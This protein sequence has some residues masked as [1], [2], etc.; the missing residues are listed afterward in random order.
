M[1]QQAILIVSQSGRFLA[2][3]A[4]NSGYPVWVADCFGDSDTLSVASR[5]LPINDISNPL[6]IL[7]TIITLSNEDP[8]T[9]IYGSGIESFH[10]LLGRLPKHIKL[11][12][13][14]QHTVEKLKNPSYF[15]NTLNKL[16]IPYPKITLTPPIDEK[17]WLS[18]SASGFGGTHIEHLT[19]GSESSNTYYQQYINGI[20][21]SVLFLASG[22][23]SQLLSINQQFLVNDP[24]SPFMLSGLAT[25]LILSHSQQTMLQNIIK[26]L[27]NHINLYGLNSL[28]FIITDSGDI[29]VLEVNP[30][31]SAS[32]EL[33]TKLP[34][35]FNLHVNACQEDQG[36]G[37]TSHPKSNSTYLHYIFARYN[38]VIPDNISWP[39]MCRDIPLPGHLILKKAPLCT[40]LI[41]DSQLTFTQSRDKVQ[42][43]IYNMLEPT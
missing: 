42:N 38:T 8:C 29:L 36:I 27:L 19:A 24:A 31:P 35:L 12:G 14:D 23:I 32:A 6:S 11:L 13:N 40:A 16:D 5:W 1:Q 18:K 9:L 39:L 3:I 20:S 28:D 22:K 4:N 26:S 41:V 7:E 25:P 10:S 21:G 43:H 30:R 33:L 34:Q 2:Q 37:M 17:G 15:F